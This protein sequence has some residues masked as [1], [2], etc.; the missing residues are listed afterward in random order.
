MFV[1]DLQEL[2]NGRYVSQQPDKL[3]EV[4]EQASEFDAVGRRRVIVPA[5]A[6]RIL[7]VGASRP[8]SHRTSGLLS[9]FFITAFVVLRI[10][11]QVA[12][13]T[14]FRRFCSWAFR[15]TLI[16]RGAKQEGPDRK[17]GDP[18]SGG[19][20]PSWALLEYLL[21]STYLVGFSQ[22]TKSPAG[23]TLTDA[24][25]GSSRTP[26]TKSCLCRWVIYLN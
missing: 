8:L 14:R 23:R 21:S 11:P 5:V 13:R 12:A 9:V 15:A 7:R 17:L 1:G 18:A 25:N 26:T 3:G 2:F 24:S 10:S 4:P 16:C 6:H 20:G 19:I 22:L